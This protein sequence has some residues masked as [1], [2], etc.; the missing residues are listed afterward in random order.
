MRAMLRFGKDGVMRW[1]S[2][3]DTIR[4]F[5]KAFR[6]ADL[7]LS[8]SAGFN[9]RPKMSSAVPL[10]LGLRSRGEYLDIELQNEA[11]PDDL[12]VKLGNVLPLGMQVL[13][14]AK[15]P[16]SAPPL[17][18]LTQ[19]SLFELTL[20]PDSGR[21]WE[22]ACQRIIQYPKLLINRVDSK[23][24]SKEIDIRQGIV[25][26]RVDENKQ[27]VCL[28]ATIETS[29]RFYLRLGELVDVITTEADVQNCRLMDLNPIRID[30]GVRE[31]DRFCSLS[32]YFI[33][34]SR[35]YPI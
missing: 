27:G 21:T 22:D 12:V 26:L 28:Q 3:L 30:L 10:A 9:P 16:Y 29:S 8:T 11:N 2:H 6:R 20:N 5:E 35:L 34:A 1:I 15:I 33:L 18:A 23:G 19:L 25:K 24:N 4:T 17:M 13:S 14:A 7:A 31:I 32:D